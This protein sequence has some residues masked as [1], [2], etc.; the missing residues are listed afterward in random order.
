MSS[1]NTYPEKINNILDDLRV[2]KEQNR[3]MK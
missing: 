3:L 1:E 2:Q